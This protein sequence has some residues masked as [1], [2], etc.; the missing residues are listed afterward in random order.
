MV[1]GQHSVAA[2]ALGFPRASGDGPCYSLRHI[3][4]LEFPPRERGWSL[5]T[6]AVMNMSNVSPARAGMVL[7]QGEENEN[8]YRFPRASGDGPDIWAIFPG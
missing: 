5:N 2:T 3:P 8:R 4:Q 1:P 6:S 7:T